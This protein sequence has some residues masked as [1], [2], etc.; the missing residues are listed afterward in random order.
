MN[1]S[2]LIEKLAHIL[3]WFAFVMRSFC[4]SLM[5]LILNPIN[6]YTVKFVIKPL[7]NHILVFD[8][9]LVLSFIFILYLRLFFIEAFMFSAPVVHTQCGKEYIRIFLLRKGKRMPVQ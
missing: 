1:N 4:I 2:R 7:T 9:F 5:D 3:S 6:T 8:D